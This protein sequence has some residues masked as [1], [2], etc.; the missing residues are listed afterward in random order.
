MED[1]KLHA[2]DRGNQDEIETP[3]RPYIHLFDC[4]TVGYLILSEAGAIEDATSSAARIMGHG[5]SILIGR[6]FPVFVSPE[7]VETFKQHHAK[8]LK[9]AGRHTCELKLL[10]KDKTALEVSMESTLAEDDAG[11][12]IRSAV[13]DITERKRMERR[14]KQEWYRS[15]VEVMG[16]LAWTANPAGQVVEDIPAWRAFTGQSE[17]EVLGAGWVKAL[18]PDDIEHTLDVWSQALEAQSRYEVEY[19]V[20][21]HDGVYRHMLA[22]AV[23]VGKEDGSIQEWV[24]ACV[25]ITERKQI[26]D[27]QLFLTHC[28]WVAYGE[29]VFESLARHLSETLEMDYVCIDRLEGDSLSAR[30]VAIYFDGK[31]DDNVTYTLKD[32]PC[33]E[34]VKRQICCFVS[35][36]RHLFPDDLVLQQ[37]QAESYVGTILR[38]SHGQPIGLIAVIGRRPLTN[39]RQAETILRLVGMRAA[40]ELERKQADEALRKSEE[41]ARRR[42]EELEKLMDLVPGGIWVAQDSECRSIV[43]NRAA[44]QMYETA[45]GKNVSAGTAVGEVLNTERRF[46]SGDRELRPEE[47]PMQFSVAKGIDVR[48]YELGVLLPSGRR[49]T[50]LGNC[51]PLFDDQGRVRGG[52]GIF[53]DITERKRVEDALRES[54][55]Q[56]RELA[57]ALPHLVWI[58]D[59]AG[60]VLF[61]NRRLQ[62]ELGIT[63]EQSPES[64]AAEAVHPEDR[65]RA[66]STWRRCIE[67]GENFETEYRQRAASGEY[68]WFLVRGIPIRDEQGQVTR[69]FGSYT[70]IED[71]KRAEE[72][73]RQSQKL[74]SIG[75]LAGGI[76]HEFNNLLASIIGNASLAEDMLPAEHPLSNLL[77]R[78]IKTGNYAAHLVK[79]LLAYS[80]QGRFVIERVNLSE[81]VQET[82]A[83]VKPSVSKQITLQLDLDRELPAVDADRSQL[84]QIFTNLVLNASEALD[85]R[86]GLISI[87][88][89]TEEVDEA[90]RSDEA[91]YS[92]LAPGRYVYLQVRDTGPGMDEATRAKI[93]DPF[94]TTKFM[95]R[96]LGLAAVSGIVRGH[97]GAIK[98]TT[99]VGSGACFRVLLPVAGSAARPPLP[100]T[101]AKEELRGTGTVLLVDDEEGVR[102]MAKQALERYGYEVLLAHDGASAIQL[103]KTAP[104]RIGVVVLDLRMSGQETL[105][106]LRR[107]RPG[108]KI[109]VSS[110]YNREEAMARIAGARVA[111]FLQKPYTVRQLASKVKAVIAADSRS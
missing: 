38:D 67:T 45:S 66:L 79:Q 110:G 72:R 4:S 70:D 34:V 69:W 86:A 11:V 59:A 12:F 104:D 65:D 50:M 81:L 37:M 9:E 36:V 16:Q 44:G 27:T 35:E 88:T 98:V 68:R 43:G 48:D 5:Q 14:A 47:L 17:E 41:T 15:Y 24:G 63:L 53:I 108:V 94:F 6:S 84:Q 76:A 60:R 91:A 21:R 19:R 49:M 32:T 58:T 8:T 30:T 100:T 42:A 20:R 55:R 78:V 51:S 61:F 105:P 33:G 74:E 10:T 73:L 101:P 80:G 62:E 85:D 1:K 82:S 97:K 39:P 3:R 90:R 95:G 46:F 2:E 13:T 31:F 26:E 89:G 103:F 75:L 56:F 99:G 29:D 7:S 107:I 93:F 22:R 28:G 57:E 111:G 77:V 25:D 18:H 106:E 87:R 40:R 64:R 92:E 83:L 102:Q 71:G 54:E 23:P 52:L 109:V 96:G